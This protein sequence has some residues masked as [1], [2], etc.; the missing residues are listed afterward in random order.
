MKLWQVQLEG[1]GFVIDGMPMTFELTGFVEADGPY[2][3]VR[4]PRFRSRPFHGLKD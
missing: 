1:E 3:D 4:A 2:P